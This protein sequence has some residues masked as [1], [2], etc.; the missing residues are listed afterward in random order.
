MDCRAFEDWLNDGRP[1][2]AAASAHDHR[3]DC[4]ACAESFVAADALESALSQR[5]ATT[6][7]GFTDRVMARLPAPADNP[8]RLP[9]DPGSPFPW[10]IQ[11]VFEPSAILGLALGLVYAVAA[12]TLFGTG[13]E[14][15]PTVLNWISERTAPLPQLAWWNNSTAWLAAVAVLGGVSIALFRGSSR[16]F[17]HLWEH[18]RL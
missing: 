8:I 2:D 9:E 7:A 11:I 1:R 12:P 18:G 4:P 5:F 13:Q 15:L 6:P 10:W 14:T 16:L 3:A 17:D